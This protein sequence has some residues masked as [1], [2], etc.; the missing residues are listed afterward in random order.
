MSA[1]WLKTH[2]ALAAFK[3]EAENM[4]KLPPPDV[5]FSTVNAVIAPYISKTKAE[6]FLDDNT[7][8][9]G[10]LLL[11]AG[12]AVAVYSSCTARGGVP[13]FS[14]RDPTKA[15]R[16]VAAAKAALPLPLRYN[17]LRGPE[18]LNLFVDA[19]CV[20]LGEPT[21]HTGLAIFT[22]AATAAAGPLTHD[23]ASHLIYPIGVPSNY[24]PLHRLSPSY[25]ALQCTKYR[26]FN[27]SE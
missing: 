11:R 4:S 20:K 1:V 25:Y 15:T 2:K 13:S 3:N 17:P 9:I 10:R 14:R 5:E 18:R 19:S 27:E 22:T 7:D 21:A 24:P 12:A 23:G 8:F 26:P 6:E 16:V